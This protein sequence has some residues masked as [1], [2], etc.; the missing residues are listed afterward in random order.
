MADPTDTLTLSIDSADASDELT[1]PTAMVDLLAEDGES[2]PQIVGDLALFGLAQ[3]IHAAVHHGQDDPGEDL[4]NL[5]ELTLELFEERFGMS[6]GEATG[7]S[8]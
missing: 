2:A 4:Q 8:H 7:H 6:Y 1:I 3:R 5:E